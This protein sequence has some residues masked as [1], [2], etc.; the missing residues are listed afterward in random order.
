MDWSSF[1][2]VLFVIWN[3]IWSNKVIS[4]AVIFIIICSIAVCN[5]ILTLR[6]FH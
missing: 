1:K 4:L 2:D 3:E 6:N 5:M